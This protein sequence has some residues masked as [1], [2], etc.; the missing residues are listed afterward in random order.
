MTE[1]DFRFKH[2]E[3]IQYYQLIEMRLKSICAA[4]LADEEK[5]WYKRLEDY[6]SDSMGGLIRNIWTIQDQK[7]MNLFSKD[8]IDVLDNLRNTR[9]YWAHE[10]F[11]GEHPVCFKKGEVKNPEH[12]K[13][14]IF[15]YETAV[16]W[17][18]KLADIFKALDIRI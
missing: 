8:D 1:T 14:I 15:D 3:L 5:G 2:S 4:L 9:N 13:R 17:D 6:E 7:K 10:C 16:E 11:G 12:T 18:E